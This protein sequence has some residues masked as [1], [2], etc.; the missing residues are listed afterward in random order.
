[1]NVKGVECVNDE[2]QY[3]LEMTTNT[4]GI[5]DKKVNTITIRQCMVHYVQS[6]F[7]VTNDDF[8]YANVK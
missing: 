2:I 3:V 6:V 7:G 8:E 4:V 5:D 1:M